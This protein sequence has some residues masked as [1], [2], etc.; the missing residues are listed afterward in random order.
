LL[1]KLREMKVVKVSEILKRLKDEGWIIV[2]QKGSHKQFKHIKKS[3]KV[4][5]NGKCS[6]D[7]TGSLLKSIEKQ[8]GIKF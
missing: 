4:T 6:D 2:H 3:G 1:G 8:A 7:V 5:I